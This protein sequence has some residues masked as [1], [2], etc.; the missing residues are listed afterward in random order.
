MSWKQR[1]GCPQ[2][3]C[4]SLWNEED[5]DGPWDFHWIH[6]VKTE[7][8]RL[9]EK[10]SVAVL[11]CLNFSEIRMSCNEWWMFQLPENTLLPL[12][13]RTAPHHS[14][15]LKVWLPQS[16]RTPPVFQRTADYM[17][18]PRHGILIVGSCIHFEISTVT[19]A[20]FLKA[21]ILQLG[22]VWGRCP[23]RYAAVVFSVGS[24]KETLPYVD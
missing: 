5:P 14:S 21:P 6:I 18:N 15:A 2:S 1:M 24:Y 10:V 20:I 12:A 17:E 8:Y 4:L 7:K 19:H 22:K 3:L 9:I 16:P 11:F 23:Q 13:C